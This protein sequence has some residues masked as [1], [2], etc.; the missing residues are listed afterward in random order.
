MKE[1]IRLKLGQVFDKTVEPT[2][3]TLELL[4]PMA[5]AIPALGST[6]EGAVESVKVILKY[7][8]VST[9]RDII[10]E[11]NS[12]NIVQSVRQNKAAAKQLAE[13][14]KTW[15]TEI[16]ESLNSFDADPIQLKGLEDEVDVLTRYVN[17]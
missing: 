4:A 5:K 12:G 10:Y 17:C 16:V 13:D 3:S 8:Q 15:I 14:A 7:A 1:K 2:I 6:V 11:S 9:S